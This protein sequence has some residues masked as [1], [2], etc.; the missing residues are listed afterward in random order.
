MGSDRLRIAVLT[1][2]DS[3]T[4]AEDR[5]G[6][7]LVAALSSAGHQLAE[8]TLVPDDVYQIRAVLSR[9]IADADVPIVIT[10]GGTGITG[11]DRTPEA[12]RPLLDVE[13]PAFGERFRA[14][15]F[16]E[17]GAAAFA[18]RALAGIANATLI[19]SLPGS[20]SACRSAWDGI[21]A[22]QLVANH[23]TCNA[24]TLMPRWG[25]GS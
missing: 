1:I 12:L 18:S 10:T 20:P 5:S 15:S 7:A 19:F 4:L 23:P 6:D 16:E 3:R 24:R 13:I 14:L 21:I 17:I 8:R 25:E 2:S 11:R 22:E 9:W